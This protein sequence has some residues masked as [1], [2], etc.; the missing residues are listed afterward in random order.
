MDYY[1]SLLESYQLLKRRQFKLSIREE[2]DAPQ[3]ATASNTEDI[4]S[5][6]QGK[7]E[8]YKQSFKHPLIK[9]KKA[10][11]EVVKTASDKLVVKVKFG[12]K[13]PALG[14]SMADGEPTKGMA[15]QFKPNIEQLEKWF[16][17]TE[18]DGPGKEQGVTIK[19]ER[20]APGQGRNQPLEVTA[21]QALDSA[22][23]SI[24]KTLESI[25]TP[26]E[27]MEPVDYFPGFNVDKD[28]KRFGTR[29]PE[30][31]VN[32][33]SGNAQG[34]GGNR[35]SIQA[36]LFNTPDE[37]AP[38]E[39]R[40]EAA[41]TLNRTLTFIQR[42]R[43]KGWTTPE[44]V[45]DPQTG[46]GPQ[47]ILELRQLADKLESHKMG[48][49]FNGIFFFY[50]ENSSAENDVLRNAVDQLNDTIDAYNSQW[51]DSSDKTKQDNEIPNIKKVKVGGTGGI[52]ESWRGPVAEKM[53]RVSAITSRTR[54]LFQKAKTKAEKRKVLASHRKQLGEVYEEAL[55]DGSLK[56]LQQIFARGQSVLLNEVV[57]D[58]TNM[59][60][61]QY[62]AACT[63]VMTDRGMK[64]EDIAVM[65]EMIQDDKTM[66]MAL[67]V[68]SF[69][70]QNFDQD[71]FGEEVD[72]IPDDIEHSGTEAMN[73]YGEK[74]DVRFKW[75]S[76][77]GDCEKVKQHYSN[78]LGDL[79]ERYKGACGTTGKDA[80]AGPDK[81]MQTTDDGKCMMGVEPKTLTDS[82]S[83]FGS[84]MVSM[85]RTRALCKYTADEATKKGSGTPLQRVG[86]KK[87][88]VDTETMNFWKL[89]QERLDNCLGAGTSTNACKKLNAVQ[90]EADRMIGAMQ[91]G[92]GVVGVNNGAEATLELWWSNKTQTKVEMIERHEAAKRA[93]TQTN[94]DPADVKQLKKVHDDIFQ[95][96]LMRDMPKGKMDP[97]NPKHKEWIDFLSQEYHLGVGTDEE[98]LRVGR[99]LEDGFQGVYLNNAEVAKNLRDIQSGEALW[100]YDG[101]GTIHLV[102]KHEV[103][104]FTDEELESHKLID[105]EGLEGEELTKAEKKNEQAKKRKGID[106]RKVVAE[107]RSGRSPVKVDTA[108]GEWKYSVPKYTY[109][110]IEGDPPEAGTKEEDILITFLR[111]QQK[112]LEKILIQTN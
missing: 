62:V 22:V 48:V 18:Q 43:D 87:G 85:A 102:G 34:W 54:L 77:D 51:A 30:T 11:A 65:L 80:W 88:E 90:A 94:P 38:M 42:R 23:D 25:L 110:E 4:I 95:A 14:I 15:G 21:D 73:S 19:G 72:L 112:L 74:E 61:A 28:G 47:D 64:P 16:A 70:N 46:V 45:L 101:G 105:T 3:G 63:K 41:E 8:N 78:L 96:V 36:Q 99:G 24:G 108:R 83:T 7:D 40:V 100:T 55:E 6:M 27:G 59:N 66:G 89:H 2:E 10:T 104:G 17:Q 76:D 53:M 97:K 5:A 37:M 60:E 71:L 57:G 33:I 58:L 39:Q 20:G 111:G 107:G 67:I 31:L 35:D 86:G 1:Y 109:N 103:R 44:G 92:K 82:K 52:E 9:D 93:L 56:D 69:A 13:G 91:P 75:D 81:M 29:T 12:Q 49:R 68:G 79:T 98:M 50:R 106:Q 26:K 32:V 84:G